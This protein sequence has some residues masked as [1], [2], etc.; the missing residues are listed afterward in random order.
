MMQPRA[1]RYP[2]L[3]GIRGIAVVAVMIFH[4]F[5]FGRMVPA[6]GLDRAA[7]AV[8]NTG[9]V[10]VDLFFVLSGF[11]ITGILF[12]ARG[13]PRFLRTFYARRVLR[14]CP[15]YF[16]VLVVFFLVLP[17]LFPS[18]AAV[19]ANTTGQIWFWTYLSNVQIAL[20]GW[21]ASSVYVDHFWSLAIEE[22]FYLLWPFAVA[23]ISRQSL[24]RTCGVIVGASLLLRIWLHAHG[25]QTAAFVLTATRMDS[26]AIGAALALAVRDAAQLRTVL[27]WVRPLLAT[28]ITLLAVICL[29]RGGFEKSDPVVGTVGYTLIG[30]TFSGVLLLAIT[31]PEGTSGWLSY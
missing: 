17:R 16:G 5:L 4:F 22:Q 19:H 23:L 29:A 3:D 27:R 7:A 6:R 8:A 25:L 1:K 20:Y 12:D 14:I 21:S 31:A 2:A 10:G 9:W 18:S 15:V 11:L 30:L 24:V 26:L 13:E 28:T